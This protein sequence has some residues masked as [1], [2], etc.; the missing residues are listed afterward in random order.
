M[1][2]TVSIKDDEKQVWDT[3]IQKLKPD[4]AKKVSS[5]TS[6]FYRTADGIECSIRES[7][8]ALIAHGYSE[9]DRMG[10]RRWSFEFV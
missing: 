5:A 4:L 6:S 10:N 7:N 2:F 9:S 8:G 1:H 3:I